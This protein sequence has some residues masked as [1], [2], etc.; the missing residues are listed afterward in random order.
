ML[1]PDISKCGDRYLRA[2]LI[3]G[4]HSVLTRCKILPGWVGRLAK[5]RPF[6]VVV[7]TLANKMVRF[8]WALLAHD[9][10]C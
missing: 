8:M 2:L 6:N 9:Q 3:Y 4:A 5:R 1:V 7:V 10:V